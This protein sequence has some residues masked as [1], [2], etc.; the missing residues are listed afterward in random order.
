M[1][2][3][4]TF[5]RVSGYRPSAESFLMIEPP[6]P[7]CGPAPVPSEIFSQWNWDAGVLTALLFSAAF[8]VYAVIKLHLT[9][10][11]IHCGAVAWFLLF[12]LFV[13]PL[14]ALTSALFS[15]RVVHHAILFAIVAPLLAI[16]AADIS[17]KTILNAGSPTFIFLAH[18]LAIWIWHAP[19]PY[20][21]ALGNGSIYWLMQV[22]LFGSGI[23]FWTH[24][25][26]SRES[27]FVPVLLLLG[28]TVHMA[29]LGTIITFAPHA[30]YEPHFQTTSPW[31]LTPLE[32]QQLGGLIMWIPAALPYLAATAWIAARMIAP[33]T[34][35]HSS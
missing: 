11:Q 12:V 17:R 13:S 4:G 1:E 19:W 5:S 21:L 23:V 22:T 6:I 16:A 30:L 8:G 32:D 14:C 2:S 9:R 35:T 33:R 26:K 31:R 20:A 3:I 25:L 27:R 24:V 29:L 7:Y 28:T 34:M 15:A 10:Y 18:M